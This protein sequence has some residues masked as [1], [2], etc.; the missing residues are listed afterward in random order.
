TL[1]RLT[2]DQRL[3]QQREETGASQTIAPIEHLRLMP[4]NLCGLTPPVC[5]RQRASAPALLAARRRLG[6]SFGT[7]VARATMHFSWV[8]RNSAFRP[9]AMNKPNKQSQQ[10]DT[11]TWVVLSLVLCAVAAALYGPLIWELT[12]RAAA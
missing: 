3:R 5:C 2:P 4:G 11:W 8:A 7:A 1:A 12:H 9:S 6:V 10:P